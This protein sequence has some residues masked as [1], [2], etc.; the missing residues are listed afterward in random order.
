M[1]EVK[2]IT[3]VLKTRAFAQIYSGFIKIPYTIRIVITT[4]QFI[5][6]SFSHSISRNQSKQTPAFLKKVAKELS[7]NDGIVSTSLPTFY[8]SDTTG[9]AIKK[10][11]DKKETSVKQHPRQARKK[12]STLGK[13]ED[14][15]KK[16][17][18]SNFPQCCTFLFSHPM[19]RNWSDSPGSGFAIC[20]F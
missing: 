20:S 9:R 14:N 13:E 10:E 5:L 1:F 7:A 19:N 8:Q 16:L 17:P 18:A 11:W 15:N 6:L 2:W 3:Q 12:E 4:G